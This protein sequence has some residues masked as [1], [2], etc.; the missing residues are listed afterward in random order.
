MYVRMSGDLISQLALSRWLKCKP[1][2]IIPWLINAK[3]SKKN[4]DPLGQCLKYPNGCLLS[5]PPWTQI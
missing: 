3:F 2:F 1:V 4:L 5:K